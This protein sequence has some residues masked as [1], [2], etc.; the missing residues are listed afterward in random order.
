M[1]IRGRIKDGV[2]VLDTNAAVPEGA[3]VTVTLAVKPNVRLAENQRR[4][5]FPLVPSSAPGSVRLTNAMIGEIL[6]AEDASS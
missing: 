4:I 5:Q 6:D 2:V 3:E 1:V